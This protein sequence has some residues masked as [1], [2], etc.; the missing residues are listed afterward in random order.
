[1]DSPLP[2]RDNAVQVPPLTEWLLS[3]FE[4]DDRVFDEFCVGRYTREM[5]IGSMSLYFEDTEERMK[6]YLNHPLRRI[7]EWAEYEIANAQ[8]VLFWEG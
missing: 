2:T 7:R 1:M 8:G 6:P 4:D 3:E 5:Y